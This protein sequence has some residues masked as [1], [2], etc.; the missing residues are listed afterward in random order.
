MKDPFGTVVLALRAD[1]TVLAI[2]GDPDKVSTQ[3]RKPPCVRLRPQTRSRAPFGPGSEGIGLELWTGVAQ[4]FGPALD[5]LG[6]P[7]PTGAIL[8]SQLAGAVSD[9]LH[10]RG[11]INGT[12][13]IV[14][15]YAAEIGD[16]L[17]DPDN[18]WPYSTVRIEAYAAA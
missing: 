15:A 11:P 6:V 10:R 14:R 13:F 18:A 3:E 8:A 17:R 7:V 2:V 4:C 5:A 9:A 12:T 16:G 1:A